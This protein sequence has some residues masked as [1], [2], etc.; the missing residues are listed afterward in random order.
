M[1]LD[2]VHFIFTNVTDSSISS[3]ILFYGCISDGESAT[4][5]VRDTWGVILAEFVISNRPARASLPIKS[6]YYHRVWIVYKW[7]HLQ[8][9]IIFNNSYMSF[10]YDGYLNN[11][12]IIAWIKSL[13]STNQHLIF[14]PGLNLDNSNSIKMLYGK[15]KYE[16]IEYLKGIVTIRRAHALRSLMWRCVLHPFGYRVVPS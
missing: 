16:I 12:E 15:G 8:N 6:R 11:G 2:F 1:C 4:L 9:I 14:M 13:H 3:T 5:R 10:L 7:L